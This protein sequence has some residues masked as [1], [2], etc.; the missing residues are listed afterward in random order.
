MQGRT[1]VALALIV[2]AP[3]AGCIGGEDAEP[4]DS[5]Q[6]EQANTTAPTNGT[7]STEVTEGEVFLSAATP[8]VSFNSNPGTAEGPFEVPLERPSGATGH[9]IEATW[10]PATPASESL[11]VWV[12]DANTGN[13]PPQDPTSPL[14]EPPVATATG[15]SPLKLAIAED[16]LDEDTEYTI[17]VRA[18]SEMP[19]GATV[20]QPFTL[21]V[22]TFEDTTFN[23]DYTAV[24]DGAAAR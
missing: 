4:T 10:E 1:L 17:L 7:V 8:A 24:E 6:L 13:I 12:R 5:D 14:P 18:P 9:V 15:S 3:M 22:T 2:A 19:V 11:D 20:D 23:S 16:D 21:H